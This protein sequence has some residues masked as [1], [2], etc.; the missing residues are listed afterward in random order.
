MMM[1][2]QHIIGEN[3]LNE[4][5]DVAH[6]NQWHRMK[7][8][9]RAGVERSGTQYERVGTEWDSVEES[10]FSRKERDEIE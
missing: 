7:L 5:Y 3:H 1:L 8:N 6:S 10:G 9:G 4:N 2:L